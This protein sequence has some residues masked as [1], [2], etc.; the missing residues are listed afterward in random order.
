M[1]DPTPYTD[2][3]VRHLVALID[4]GQYRLRTALLR[5]T[6]QRQWARVLHSPVRAVVVDGEV[7][8]IRSPEGAAEDAQLTLD[9][10]VLSFHQVTS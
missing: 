1:T 10:L 9:S 8:A 4:E 6:G 7:V 3:D 5:V 2:D